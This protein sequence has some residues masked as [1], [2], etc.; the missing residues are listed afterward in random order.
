M[1]G[2]GRGGRTGLA[3]WLAAPWLA[4]CGARPGAAPEP[5]APAV[6][7]TTPSAASIAAL[8]QLDPLLKA[9]RYDEALD[10][11]QTWV[12]REPGAVAH[13]LALGMIVTERDGF[14]AAEPRFAEALALDPNHVPTL[15]ALMRGYADLGADDAVG[16][17]ERILALQP[18]D[19][20]AAAI[21][22]RARIDAGDY[23]GALAVLTPAERSGRADVFSLIGRAQQRLGD[24]AAAETSFRRALDLDARSLEALLNLGQLLQR[25]GRAE[26]GQRLLDRHKSVSAEADALSFA[27]GSSQVEGAGAAN[28]LVLGEARL[29]QGDFAGAEDAFERAAARDP[30]EAR[31]PLGLAMVATARQAHEAALGF[32]RQAVALDGQ[33]AMAHLL[34]GAAEVRTGQLEA[35]RRSFER[36][37]RLAAWQARDWSIAGQAFFD[38]GQLEDALAAY[39]AGYALAPEDDVV[40][41]RLGFLHQRLGQTGAARDVLAPA[42]ARSPDNADLALALAI[43]LDRA[44]DAGAAAMLDEAVARQRRAIDLAPAQRAAR[45]GVFEGADA[46]LEAFV[47]QASS[48]PAPP[49]GPTAAP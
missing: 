38:A 40:A 1:G 35:G 49:S 17:A 28:F 29:N 19:G 45:F 39:Q 37:Q 5:T 2:G 4:A 3:L 18:S 34:L 8:Q 22:G 20:E 23:E 7:V 25:T 11:V 30:K 26:E 12:A 16:Y 36:S 32:A 27:E 41:L 43:V 21:V 9:A 15:A 31:A 33:Q 46:V 24:A 47:E 42:V 14:E 10:L 48:A 6:A 13:R 44:G